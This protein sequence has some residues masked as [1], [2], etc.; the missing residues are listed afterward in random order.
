MSRLWSSLSSKKWRTPLRSL[1]GYAAVFVLCGSLHAAAQPLERGQQ[2]GESKLFLDGGRIRLVGGSDHLITIKKAK[3]IENL[4]KPDTSDW[5]QSLV[6]L[7]D[8][9]ARYLDQKLQPQTLKIPGKK[10]V[11]GIAWGD[12]VVLYRADSDTLVFQS[13]NDQ[14]KEVPIPGRTGAPISL[15]PDRLLVMGPKQDYFIISGTDLTP[16][17]FNHPFPSEKVKVTVSGESAL[18]WSPESPQ[19]VL[20]GSEVPTTISEPPTIGV[21]ATASGDWAILGPSKLCYLTS[22]GR[23]FF[24]PRP[25]AI[26]PDN[27]VDSGIFLSNDSL[28]AVT[29]DAE[30]GT[31]C[32]SVNAAGRPS[33]KIFKGSTFKH[34]VLPVANSPGAAFLFSE[35]SMEEPKVEDSGEPV[36]DLKTGKPAMHTVK[37]TAVSMLD[38]SNTWRPLLNDPRAR[39]AGPC[40]RV[41]DL[42]L[43]AT[44]TLPPNQLGIERETNSLY[45]Y[46]EVVLHALS[47]QTGLEVWRTDLPRGQA[48][49]AA[50]MPEQDWPLTTHNKLLLTSEDS[51]LEAIDPATGKMLWSSSTLPLD[52]SRPKMLE[53]NDVVGL[54]ATDNTTK[55]LVLVNEADGKILA[56]LNLNPYFN[57]QRT[58]HLVGV[59]VICLAL[60]LYIY[61]AGKRKLFIRRIAG[62]EALDEAVG[63][64]TEMGKPVLYV[65][66]LADI[67]DI[68]TLASLSI[69]SHVSKKTADYDS[70]IIATTSRAVTFSAAQE[71]VR[72]AFTVAG[73]PDSFS[74]E[75]VQYIS[76]DQFGYAAG[77]D[78]IMLRDEPAANFYMGNFFAESLIFAETGYATGA[79]QIAGTAQVS[80]LPF[81]VAACDYT[82]IGEELFAASAYLSGDPLQ[83][84]SLR[85]QDVGKAIVMIFLILASLDASTGAHLSQYLGRYL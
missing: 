32:L 58:L 59:S 83:V 74:V 81:F 50:R 44:Q 31:I 60:L 70:S 13:A 23:T 65:T 28:Q 30:Q 34:L 40:Q 43:Y 67:D 64:A 49:S 76:D 6:A 77:V 25:Q 1:A 80:Q 33:G 78:G 57:G 7:G 47:A 68:Q 4:L 20:A 55:S 16:K 85:G 18:L 56:E 84:G 21:K 79:I 27:L 41:G 5:A 22:T 53:W 73:R 61:L 82:L 3:G 42:V 66:G 8:G 69:L 14:S 2:W 51:R 36:L 19:V 62:L 17:K 48:P 45:P 24:Y 52:E 63:R 35:T 12:F 71:V 54:V 72:D 26:T 11:E 39:L 75:S 38:G 15:G 9:A 46:P 37:G 29:P 10:P